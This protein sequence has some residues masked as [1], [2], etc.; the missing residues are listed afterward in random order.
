MSAILVEDLW[1]SYRDKQARPPT[2]KLTLADLR[3]R[4]RRSSERWALKGVSFSVDRGEMLSV[5][6]HNGSGKSTLLR[7]LAGI[8]RPVRGRVSVTGRTASLI[9][10]TAG[11]HRLLTARENVMLAGAIYGIPRGELLASMDEI[12]EFAGLQGEEETHLRAYS[13]G[14][15]MRLGFSIAVVFEPDVLLVDEVLAV[16]DEAF[17]LKCLDKVAEL[18][19]SGATIVFVSHELAIVRSLSDRVLVL[20]EGKILHE[21]GPAEAIDAYCKHL[22]VDVETALSRPLVQQP[23]ID[24]LDERW[25]GRRARRG[26]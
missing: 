9:D 8:Y 11:F 17:K 20:D 16:G 3:R 1:Q 24:A 25:G 6:G 18:R 23:Q 5:I 19:E 7:S 26:V 12:F 14:M 2:L 13:T 15:A 10:L 4:R 21:G 22:G